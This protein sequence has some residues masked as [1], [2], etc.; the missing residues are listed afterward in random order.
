MYGKAFALY[1]W[2]SSSAV[3]V[4]LHGINITALVLPWSVIVRI[5]SN[6]F[7]LGSLTIKSM[8]IV[9]KGSGDPSGFIGFSGGWFGC[10]IALFC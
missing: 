7:D 6:S 8:L 5:E 1:S 2:A 3:I 10:V 9:L 4:S